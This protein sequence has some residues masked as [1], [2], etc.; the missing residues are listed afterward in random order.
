MPAQGRI[1][2]MLMP[3]VHRK[4][5]LVALWAIAAVCRAGQPHLVFDINPMPVGAG[6]FP[7]SFQTSGTWS[8]FSAGDGT[9]GYSPWVTDGTL[10]GTFLWGRVSQSDTV[11]FP[12]IQ[13]GNKIYLS[14]LTTP[15]VDA[16]L[17]VSDGTRAGSHIVGP[18]LSDPNWNN[19]GTVGALGSRLVFTAASTTTG[20]R[21]LW[22]ADGL[23]DVGTHVASNTGESYSVA[24]SLIVNNQIYFLSLDS[25]GIYEPWVSDGTVPGTKRLLAVPQSVVDNNLSPELALVGKYIIFAQTTVSSGRELWRIDTTNN[26]V[27]QVADI[28]AGSAPGLSFYPRFA[29]TGSAAV[30]IATPDG[31]T[32]SLWRTDG[33]SAGTYQI[34]ASAPNPGDPQFFA[35]AGTPRVIYF[36]I[37][38]GV[39]QAWAT[40]GSVAGTVQLPIPGV[41]QGD[42]HLVGTHFYFFSFQGNSHLV[43]RSDGTVAGTTMVSGLNPSNSPQASSPLDVAGDES[44]VFIR[45]PNADELGGTLYLYQPASG[46][47]TQLLPYSLKAP[48]QVGFDIF[49]YVNGLLYFD[50]EDS[51]TGHE[52]WTSDGSVLGTHILKNIAPDV[53]THTQASDPSELVE[54]NGQLYFAANDGNVGREL[55][56]S[57]GINTQLVADLYGGVPDSN[58]TDLFVA[59]GSLFLFALDGTNT[60][61]LWRSD[62]TAAGTVPIAA[63]APRPVPFRSPGCDSKGVLVGN[64]IYFA[65]YDTTAGVQLWK[66]DGT[67]AGTQRVTATP[68][69]THGSFGVCY[70]T[71]FNGRIYFSAGDASSGFGRELWVSDGTAAGTMML[72]DIN[73]GPADSSP[74]FLTA[75]ASHLY[76]SADDGSHG[77]NLWASDGTATGSAQQAAFAT[78]PVAAILGSASGELFVSATNGTTTDLWSTDG[79]V[80]GRTSLIQGLTGVS[81]LVAHGD[82][83]FGASTGAGSTAAAS[84]YVSDGTASATRS[85]FTMPGVSI[86]PDSLADFHGVTLFQTS[87]QT[88]TGNLWRTD[89]TASG[90]KALGNIAV[91]AGGLTVGQNFFFV[92]DD[93]TTGAELWEIT[94]EPPFVPEVDLGSVAAGQSISGN[95]LTGA[96]DPDGSIDT[97]SLSISQPPIGGTLTLGAGGQVTYAANAGFSGQDTFTFTV[98][99]NQGL[100]TSGAGH[101]T[102]TAASNPG[103]P[104]TQPPPATGSGGG[105]ALS[106]DIL[107]LLLGAGAARLRK[108]KVAVRDV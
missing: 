60:A 64:T 42:V 14:V 9:H 41:V 101:V 15:N 104:P 92:G 11:G 48:P 75:F 39:P 38:G 52:V 61:R 105:G 3:G 33:T 98:A 46:T 16:I 4:C 83:Y 35:P 73:S 67:A 59:N 57:D 108:K 82:V 6:A 86:T 17:W 36:P 19:V 62:G 96:T 93:G 18:L 80:G 53:P 24:N 12:S 5:I 58:P 88:S 30:F 99:D 95:L 69:T 10:L 50:N 55:W 107:L 63:V 94:N 32:P 7:S 68:S 27:A 8:Y 79:T 40:D 91:G 21:E 20:S 31:V 81:A 23:G 13:A 51:T 100:A 28:A 77:R 102:V 71:A 65:G 89:G 54:F 2:P 29:S 26:S 44:K 45:I 70:L 85:I 34:A 37:V 56:S 25:S 47:S 106:V 49:A 66:T 74:Q 43:W 78:G 76:F 97:Q 90:T 87:D 22:I 1:H 72:D 103:G 84:V